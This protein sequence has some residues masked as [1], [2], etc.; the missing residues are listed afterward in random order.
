MRGSGLGGESHRVVVE[1]NFLKSVFGGFLY[2]VVTH[3]E[4]LL[5]GAFRETASD[6]AK[7][8]HRSKLH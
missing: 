3:E 4:A 6:G 2:R 1:L 5:K 7:S 8:A